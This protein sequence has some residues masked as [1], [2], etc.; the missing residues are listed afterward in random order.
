MDH[1]LHPG[2][3]MQLG[4]PASKLYAGCL[5]CLPV[6]MFFS[7]AALDIGALVPRCCD[8]FALTFDAAR[9][10]SIRTD[11]HMTIPNEAHDCNVTRV[12]R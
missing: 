7:P 12:R 9:P 1:W 8:C 11:T 3:R 2:A 10:L 6:Q 4:M 5:V